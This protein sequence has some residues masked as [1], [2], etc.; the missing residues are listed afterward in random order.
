[1]KVFAFENLFFMSVQRARP[2]RLGKRLAVE[3]LANDAVDLI[4]R[5]R[6]E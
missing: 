6:I 3:M 1:M 5:R 4:Q 2:Y